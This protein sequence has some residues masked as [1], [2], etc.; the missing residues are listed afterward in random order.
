M[1]DGLVVTARPEREA[2]VDVGHVLVEGRRVVVELGVRELVGLRL[3]EVEGEEVLGVVA[4]AGR[5]QDAVGHGHA[6]DAGP[7]ADGVRVRVEP[8]GPVRDGERSCRAA[9]CRAEVT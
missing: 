9:P 7:V 8:G 6:L 3:P 4:R 5:P 1:P 2:V